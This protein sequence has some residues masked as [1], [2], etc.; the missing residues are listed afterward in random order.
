MPKPLI[1]IPSESM[2]G[3]KKP[4]R[5][6]N[7]LLRM[8]KATRNSVALDDDS[9]T[10]SGIAKDKKLNVFK[11]YTKDLIKVRE[12]ILNDT[13][14]YDDSSR[15]AFVSSRTFKELGGTGDFLDLSNIQAPPPPPLKKVE[16]EVIDKLLIGTDP[17]LLLML[18]GKV[19][20]ASGID[21]FDKK[22]KFGSD[23]AMAEMRP[24]PALSAEGL[25]ANIQKILNDQKLQEK[26][27]K[28]DLI[29]SCYHEEDARDY[30]VGTHI[31]IDN[32]AKIAQLPVEQRYRLFAVTNKIMDELLTVPAVR[33]D[34]QKGHNRRAKC[35]MS[36]HNGYGNDYGKGY[37]FFGEWRECHGRLEH[38]SMSGLVLMNPAVAKAVFGTAQAIAEA[39]YNE[40][41]QNDLNKDFI[42][43][44]DFDYKNIYKA[45]FKKWGDIPLAE[46]LNCT[47]SSKEIATLMDSSDRKVVSTGYIKKWLTKIRTLSTYGKFSE[48]IEALGDILSSSD[49][50]IDGLDTNIKNTWKD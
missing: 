16:K 12:F 2:D 21:G 19:V 40:A 27:S 3:N 6:E 38:R 45:T 8:A 17:E 44:N 14:Q 4:D 39:V 22:A 11:A 23:G 48:H 41:L 29:S 5:D 37:G 32:P 20:N 15:V 50:V 1:I 25:V 35:R 43:P 47:L 10:L 24:D 34:G 30:P 36:T 26:V 42:L 49:K 28:Y 31:H 18:Q 9:V 13:L 46:T 33:L 7:V